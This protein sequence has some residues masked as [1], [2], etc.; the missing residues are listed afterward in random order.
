VA[1]RGLRLFI[2]RGAGPHLLQPAGSE[3]KGDTG[4]GDFANATEGRGTRTE[5]PTVGCT[6]SF[7]D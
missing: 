7:R 4:E 5:Q 6:V 3:A 1:R 2:A